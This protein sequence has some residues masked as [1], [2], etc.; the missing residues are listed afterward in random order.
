MSQ[1][2][3]SQRALE[4]STQRAIWSLELVRKGPGNW[5]ED[6]QQVNKVMAAV[7]SGKLEE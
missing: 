7:D 3:N 1:F 2:N 6:P 5:G 4:P